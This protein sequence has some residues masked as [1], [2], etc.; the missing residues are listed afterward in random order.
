MLALFD[1]ELDRGVGLTEMTLLMVVR[2]ITEVFDRLAIR[3]TRL[4]VRTIDLRALQPSLVWM[5][6]YGTS[7]RHGELCA[8]FSRYVCLKLV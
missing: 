3:I 4:I 2:R 6:S 1:C 7:E 5:R 8:L